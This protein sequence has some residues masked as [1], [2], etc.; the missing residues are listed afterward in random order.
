MTISAN[1]LLKT[2]TARNNRWCKQQETIDEENIKN[3]SLNRE[4]SALAKE[5]NKKK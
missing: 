2:Q 4:A 5:E 1:Y 3:I